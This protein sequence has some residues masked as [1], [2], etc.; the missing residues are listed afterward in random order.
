MVVSFLGLMIAL[1]K[2]KNKNTCSTLSNIPHF[3]LTF[4]T[5]GENKW[6]IWATTCAMDLTL[7]YYQGFKDTYFYCIY[8][9]PSPALTSSKTL[10][11]HEGA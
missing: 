2:S 8:I 1:I 6:G 4:S 10:D 9:A 7:K 3:H 11:I 5:E